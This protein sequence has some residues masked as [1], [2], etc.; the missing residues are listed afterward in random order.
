MSYKSTLYHSG[1]DLALHSFSVGAGGKGYSQ[2][3]QQQADQEGVSYEEMDRRLQPS[4]EHIQQGQSEKH[5]AK[6]KS[7]KRLQ[8]VRDA[9]WAGSCEDDLN[10]LHDAIVNVLGFPPTTEQIHAVFNLLPAEIIAGV[11]QWGIDDTEV[12]SNASIFINENVDT[13]RQSIRLEDR[14]NEGAR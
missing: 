4:A 14:G 11:I 5:E 10:G 1:Q 13:V 2:L 7:E 8:L 3:I 6:V 12:R 9:Y